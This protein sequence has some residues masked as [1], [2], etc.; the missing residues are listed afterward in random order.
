M[1]Y[2][3]TY[4]SCKAIR[5]SAE[6]VTFRSLATHK[7]IALGGVEGLDFT[8]ALQHRHHGEIHVKSMSGKIGSENNSDQSVTGIRLCFLHVPLHSCGV[9]TMGPKPKCFWLSIH[10]LQNEMLQSMQA[11]EVPTCKKHMNFV[12]DLDFHTD[13][14][15]TSA[16]SA[17][18][19]NPHKNWILTSVEPP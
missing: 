16:G 17:S 11:E 1:N 4:P 18:Q 14:F 10:T 3:H 8:L 12:M 2:I 15:E 7:S 6:R 9:T 19:L 13:L 5:V